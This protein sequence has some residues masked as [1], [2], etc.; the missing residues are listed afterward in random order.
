MSQKNLQILTKIILIYSLFYTALKIIVVFRGAWLEAN[1]ILAIPFVLLAAWGIFILK[2]ERSSWLYAVIGILIIVLLRI[3]EK[4][5][6]I[7][8]QGYFH[9]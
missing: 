7:D 2:S 3:F 8:I 4:E 9:S 1:L 5:L 6:A